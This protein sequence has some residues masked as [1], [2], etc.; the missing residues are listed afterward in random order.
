M[1]LILSMEKNQHEKKMHTEKKKKE[2]EKEKSTT[3]PPP[4]QLC[5]SK[6]C[7]TSEQLGRNIPAGKYFE[8]SR[9]NNA[10]NECC[11]A[12]EQKP[13]SLVLNPKE[14]ILTRNVWAALKEKHQHLVGMEIFR[15]IFNRR[16]DLK[17]LFGVSAL[18][19][20]MALNSTRLH[21]H[22][23][24]FQD[25]IDILMV[26]ISNVDVNIADSLIDLGAQHWVLTK[27]GFDPAYWLIFGDVLFDLV[28]NVTRKLPSRKRSTNAWRKTIAFM[29]DCMQIGYLKGVQ[30]YAVEQ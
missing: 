7:L 10:E 9:L 23:M 1:N 3:R 26:N 22:T 6:H 11:S 19:T 29:L 5:Q 27:R 17:S 2:K 25:V 20:E 18:D 28:E 8:L 24:I 16:P 15:Q 4:S 30:C 12:D 13:I 21:R 14:V